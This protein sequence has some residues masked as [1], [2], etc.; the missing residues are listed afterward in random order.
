MAVRKSGI[1]LTRIVDKLGKSRKWIYN[2]FEMP[3]VP[4][5]II[6]EIG[7]VIHH[8]FT[9]DIDELNSASKS[10]SLSEVDEERNYEGN[11]VHYWKNK[12]LS[13]LEEFNS[14]LKRHKEN[15]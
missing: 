2:Q 6:I 14:Y 5:D 9:F 3:D 15:Q 11:E 4:L 13:L 7:K 10:K 8:D 1:P 12:Y